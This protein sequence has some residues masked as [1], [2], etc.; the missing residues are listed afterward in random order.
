MNRF[1]RGRNPKEAMGIGKIANAIEIVNIVFTNRDGGPGT[2]W[3][4][5]LGTEE[6]LRMLDVLSNPNIPITGHHKIIN[7]LEFYGRKPGKIEI[8]QLVGKFVNYRDRLYL[9]KE[10]LS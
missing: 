5:V 7:E 2:H 9:I 10:D 1:E 3:V 6:I 8:W 4:Q